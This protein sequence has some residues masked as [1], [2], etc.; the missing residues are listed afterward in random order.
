MNKAEIG[1]TRIS[2]IDVAADR[3]VSVNGPP[4]TEMTGWGLTV[5]TAE[6]EYHLHPAI[7]YELH[8][9]LPFFV[10]VHTFNGAQGRLGMGTDPL[11][12]WTAEGRGSC[13][14]PPGLRMRIVQETPL[15]FIAIGIAP[16]RFARIAAA[17]APGWEVTRAFAKVADPALAAIF[18]E[19]RRSMIAETVATGGYLD[20]LLDAMLVRL[21]GWHLAPS[22]ER[23]EGPERLA[24][25]IARRLAAAIEAALQGPI[26]VADLAAA[27][28]LSRAHFSRA[29][30]QTFGMGARDYI[31]SRRI[32]RARTL[33]TDTD[34]SASE[35]AMCCGFANPSHLTT[36]FRNE[37][38]L[39]PT[40][41][42]RALKKD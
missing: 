21:I 35:I 26:R 3:F 16:E 6:A 29:F 5:R 39:T 37:M 31:L 7:T 42:R 18:G 24:P 20:A 25:A 10:L 15:E 4:I 32:A 34:R 28:G 12:P 17:A 2:G 23:A 19:I 36:A 8:Y 41:Y 38:G 11:A 22:A 13:L 1:V 33:L 30:S 40:A 27:E 14:V 9:Q